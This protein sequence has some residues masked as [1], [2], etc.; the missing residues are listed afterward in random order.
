MHVRIPGHVLS[1]WWVGSSMTANE[2]P[3]PGLLPL[4]PLVRQVRCPVEGQGFRCR[5]VGIPGK[6]HGHAGVLRAERA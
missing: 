2:N 6:L 1:Q 5:D 4:Y 3:V